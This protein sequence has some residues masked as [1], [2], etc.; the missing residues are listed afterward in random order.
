M[1]SLCDERRSPL[2]LLVVVGLIGVSALG[3][4]SPLLYPPGHPRLPVR[5]PI[6]S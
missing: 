3:C 5:P 6:Y 1:R 4:A 2:A